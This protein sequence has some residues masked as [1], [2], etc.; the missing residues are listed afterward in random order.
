[1]ILLFPVLAFAQGTHDVI[2]YSNE[3]LQRRT[4]LYF[5]D[6]VDMQMQV[7]DRW[8]NLNFSSIAATGFGLSAY[9]IGAEH[10]WVSR[11]EAA[12]RVLKTLQILQNLPQGPQ[13]TGVSGYKGFYYHFLDHQFAL[14][15]RTTE[16]S[17]IDTGLLMA[18]I[19]S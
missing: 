6:L 7:P 12:E 2:P 1:W 5:W 17:S 4:F 3:E 9:I 10:K 18:G 15:F 14:R 8:P 19:L 11:E 13:M 16:L